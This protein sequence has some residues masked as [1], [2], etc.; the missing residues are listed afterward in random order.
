M[1]DD[2]ITTVTDKIVVF[3]DKKSKCEFRIINDKQRKIEKHR[4]DGCRIK[5]EDAPK[6]DWLAVDIESSKEIFIE[7]KGKDIEHA[8]KQLC[9]TVDQLSQNRTSK[10]LAYIIS[11]RSPL[12]SAKIDAISKKIL[13][14]HKLVLVVKTIKH[15]ENIDKLI[16]TLA[17]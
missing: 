13:G 2:C 1:S 6:C 11:T 3:S 17:S 16:A 14:S 7:L 4:I 15:S 10:K 8:I 9:A 5:G 12:N